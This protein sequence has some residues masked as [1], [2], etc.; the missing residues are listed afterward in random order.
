[1]G[2]FR[3]YRFTNEQLLAL[4]K[5]SGGILGCKP[6]NFSGLFDYLKWHQKMKASDVVKLL[7]ELPELAL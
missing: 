2:Q 6:Q 7:D 5:T 3:K 1:M 4:C